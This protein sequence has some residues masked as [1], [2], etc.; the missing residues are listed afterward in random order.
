[1]KAA[2]EELEQAAH[3]FSKTLYEN[4]GQE[5]AASGAEG[6]APDQASDSSADED[7][8]DAEF[9]VKDS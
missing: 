7:T 1:M 8:I 9:E 5:G 2:I 6:A 4:T 3:A